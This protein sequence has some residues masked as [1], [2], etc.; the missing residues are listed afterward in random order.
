LFYPLWKPSIFIFVLCLQLQPMSITPKV[1][2]FLISQKT[3]MNLTF[4]HHLFGISIIF[5][6]HNTQGYLGNNNIEWVC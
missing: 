3:L 5:Q 4:L 1:G 2:V 6:Q